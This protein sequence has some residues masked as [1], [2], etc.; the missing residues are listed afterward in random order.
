M[1]IFTLFNALSAIAPDYNTMMII[2]F[3]SGLPHGAF[4]GVGTVVATRLAE[5]VKKHSIYR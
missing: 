5:K 3:L 1:M 4:F 2:R